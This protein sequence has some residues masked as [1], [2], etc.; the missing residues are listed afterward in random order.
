[1][2]NVDFRQFIMVEGPD[3]SG[4][5]TLAR[6]LA[7]RMSQD[8][9]VHL[10]AEPSGGPIGK[11][12]RRYLSREESPVM[13]DWNTL[14]LLF[15]ADRLDHL[16]REVYPALAEGKI[17][18]CDRYVLSNI[19]YQVAT[20]T[21]GMSEKEAA[22]FIGVVN[23]YAPEPGFTILLNVP[24]DVTMA[25]V[26]ARAA[27]GGE[28]TSNMEV[29]DVARAVHAFYGKCINMSRYPDC[30]AR[31]SAIDVQATDSPQSVCDAARQKVEA[32]LESLAP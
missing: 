20:R 16:R 5:T 23:R 29:T 4:K 21:V 3:G 1:M 30:A 22:Q 17:V 6:G 28:A 8:R 26:R 11:L 12:L 24:L 31:M 18:I 19:V 14:A 9:S 25:R 2:A 7:E 27:T 13:P 32:Y 10:T 15:A